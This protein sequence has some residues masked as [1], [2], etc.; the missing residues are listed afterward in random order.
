VWWRIDQAVMIAVH[1]A[2]VALSWQIKEWIEKPSTVGIFLTLGATAAAA[3]ILRGHL[4]FTSAINPSRLAVERCRT[5]W[6]LTLFDGMMSVLLAADA[7]LLAGTRALPALLAL[8][9]GL[10][11]GLASMV[12]EPATTEATFGEER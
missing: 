5:R 9:F 4:V 3:G 12:L 6:P 2:C 11:V 7:L 10:G 1:I 8:V